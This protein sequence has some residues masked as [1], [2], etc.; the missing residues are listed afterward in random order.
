M[1]KRVCI[2]QARMNSKRLPGK[3]LMPLGDKTVLGNVIHRISKCKLIDGIVVATP[4][5]K[6]I[7]EAIKHGAHY[8]LGDEMDVLGRYCKAARFFNADIIVRITA[9]CPYIMPDI[10]DRVIESSNRFDY[11]SNILKRTYPKGFDCEVF[12]VKELDRANKIATKP[13]EREHVT[14]YIIEHT[15]CKYSVED[16]EDFS[17]SR[18]TLDTPEDYE[19]LMKLYK[20][21]GEVYDYQEVKGALRDGK[22]LSV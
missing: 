8:Y 14:P 22:T 20:H 16:K 5:P 1:N 2:I 6:I 17:Q 10:V 19:C 3:V 12:T 9:D 7:T 13:E 21:I 18:I 11:A 4:D 15:M